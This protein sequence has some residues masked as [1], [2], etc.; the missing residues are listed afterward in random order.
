VIEGALPAVTERG[1]GMPIIAALPGRLL[2]A[3]PVS[4]RAPSSSG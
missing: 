3:V 4:E 1:S 2:N